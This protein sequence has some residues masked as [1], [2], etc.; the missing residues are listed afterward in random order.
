MQNVFL[1]SEMPL[2]FNNLIV[3]I[4]DPPAF[5]REFAVLTSYQQ[6]SHQRK[7]SPCTDQETFLF[8]RLGIAKSVNKNYESAV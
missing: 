8:N 5:R 1:R 4:T 3:R 7:T 2:S 6:H